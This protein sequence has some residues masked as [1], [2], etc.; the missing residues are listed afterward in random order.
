MSLSPA[1][2]ILLSHLIISHHCASSPPAAPRCTPISWPAKLALV[3]RLCRTSALHALTFLVHPTFSYFLINTP[4]TVIVG[5]FRKR[6]RCTVHV[7]TTST[8]RDLGRPVDPKAR[9]GQSQDPNFI[10]I[11]IGVRYIHFGSLEGVT[12]SLPES[13]PDN[14]YPSKTPTMSNSTR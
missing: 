13:V 1:V 8:T 5:S 4:S 12:E 10:G 11:V 3:V 9:W 2:S 7:F 6:Y 14:Y